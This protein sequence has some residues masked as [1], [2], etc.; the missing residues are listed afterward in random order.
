V[1]CELELH[2]ERWQIL[3][4]IAGEAATD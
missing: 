3:D 1:K 2:Y 4:S